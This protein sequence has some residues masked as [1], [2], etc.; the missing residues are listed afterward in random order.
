MV[1]IDNLVILTDCRS[2]NI[3]GKRKDSIE[4]TE[5]QNYHILIQYQSLSKLFPTKAQLVPDVFI[6]IYWEQRF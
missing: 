1:H 3:I 6:G 5:V 2:Q 4:M